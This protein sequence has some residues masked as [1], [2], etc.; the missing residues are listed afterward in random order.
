MGLVSQS[1][2]QEELDALLPS[3][4]GDGSQSLLRPQEGHPRE[5]CENHVVA[6]LS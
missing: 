4:K 3:P 5:N 2:T 1:Q 6:R